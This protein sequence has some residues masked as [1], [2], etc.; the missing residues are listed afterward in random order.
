[1]KDVPFR[2]CF[3]HSVHC[4]FIGVDSPFDGVVGGREGV[5]DREGVTAGGGVDGVDAT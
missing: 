4:V 3:P 1:M 2:K 5:I